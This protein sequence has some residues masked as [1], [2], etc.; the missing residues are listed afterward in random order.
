[1]R[2]VHLSYTDTKYG[3]DR[4]T[5]RLH[6]G[7]EL[8]G[9]D[10]WMV[11]GRKFSR[12]ETVR[13]SANSL[14]EKAL[15]GMRFLLDQLPLRVYRNRSPNL[16]S[17]SWVPDRVSRHPLVS[18]S[19]IIN[20]HWICGG[21]LRPESIAKINKPIV[22]LLHDMWAFTG[23]CHYSGGC[24]GYQQE[25][26]FCPQLGSHHGKDLS[27]WLWRRKEKSWRKI[28]LTIVT[29]SR[30]LS[31]CAGSSSLFK[32]YR[33]EVIPNGIND[34]V[35]K[36]MDKLHSRKLLG[37]PMNKKIVLFGAINPT[38][39]K[40]KGI[41]YLIEALDRLARDKIRDQLELAILGTL[42][43]E[44]SFGITLPVH[45]L[46]YVEDVTRLA[47][48]YS[49]ADAFIAPSKEDNFPN[50]VL[51]SL[52]CGTPVIAFNV[53]G[54]PDLIEHMR[55]GYLVKPFDT[56][57]LGDG[58]RW[59]LSDPSR[60]EELSKRAREKVEEKFTTGI[61]AEKY[62]RLYEQILSEKIGEA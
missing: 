1:V 9:A 50:T 46:G 20:L 31:S 17:T 41:R 7:L 4:A 38:K 54:I 39:D 48:C 57:D 56:T 47:S 25:C 58:I 2:V 37:L 40:R 33:I 8:A 52:A 42:E 16:F 43:P 12:D 5:R 44:K 27:H 11:V 32:R 49:A 51:E 6:Q 45:Y 36:P 23:G 24:A 28:K 59:V 35:F 30:W 29:P 3:A 14:I 34:R 15:D 22:W 13:P 21:F 53:G 19:D 61:Q 62:I 10:S 55:E 18:S 60:S 26:G